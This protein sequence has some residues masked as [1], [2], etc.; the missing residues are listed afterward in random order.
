VRVLVTGGTGFIG[1]AVVRRLRARGDEVVVLARRPGSRAAAALAAVGAKIVAGD[2]LEAGACRAA[3]DGCSAVVHCAGRPGPAT[4]SLLTRL[5]VDATRSVIAAARA[6]GVRRVVNIA[7]QAVLFG[8]ED[9]INASDATPYPA[10]Y[11][12]PY[13]ETKAAGERIALAAHG[14]GGLEV[15]SLRPAVVWGRGDRTVL[16]IMLKL[17]RGLGIPACGPGTNIEATTH[18]ENL[19]DAVLLALDGPGGVGKA[20]LVLDGF[21]VTWRE[22]LKRTVEAAG[23]RAKF[24]TVPRAVAEPAAWA[25]DRLAGGLGLPVPLAYFGVRTALTSREFNATGARDEFGYVPR[26]G[27]EDGLADLSRW[28]ESVGGWRGVVNAA[29]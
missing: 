22:F 5:H 21:R 16:P 4:K 28:V 29:K 15:V 10:K 14:I 25:L 13:S 24:M 6:G 17:A 19:A 18:I 20:Y 9:L 7:S 12:D 1:S 26:V 3:A 8:G 23:V 2:L 27:W 11:I